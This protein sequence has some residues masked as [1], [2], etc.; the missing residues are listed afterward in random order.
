EKIRLS[1]DHTG[2]G[3]AGGSVCAFCWPSRCRDGHCDRRRRGRVLSDNFGLVGVNGKRGTVAARTSGVGTGPVLR[4][5]RRLLHSESTD[6]VADKDAPS[7]F[8]VA[9]SALMRG[10]PPYLPNAIHAGLD[11]VDVVA[12]A[13]VSCPDAA[14]ME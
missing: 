9:D 12:D 2:D 8:Y 7:P 10:I 11:P 1:A 14:L 5:Y 4:S 6:L 13:G 3:S